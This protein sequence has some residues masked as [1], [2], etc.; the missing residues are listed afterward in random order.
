MANKDVREIA[1]KDVHF[2][3]INIQ[4]NKEQ[5]TQLNMVF[6]FSSL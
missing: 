6:R 4:K 2:F 5:Q 3:M 1:I